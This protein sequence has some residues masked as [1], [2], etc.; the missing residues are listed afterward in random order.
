MPL[1]KKNSANKISPFEFPCKY[2]VNQSVGRKIL[3]KELLAKYKYF[4]IKKQSN[5]YVIAMHE[6]N[7][8]A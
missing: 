8:F 5:K 7:Y 2:I 6:S 1:Y 3:K 4:R